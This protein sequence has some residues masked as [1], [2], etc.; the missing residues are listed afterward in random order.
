M[1]YQ[2]KDFIQYQ[3]KLLFAVVSDH[4]EHGKVLCF[5]RY[6]HS[7]GRWQKLNTDAANAYLQAEYPGFLHYSAELDAHVH[8]VHTAQ[9]AQHYQPVSGLKHLLQQPQTDPVIQDLNQLC[10]LLARN[11]VDMAYFG[12]TGSVLVG[13]Q[14]Q[15]SD[16]DLVCYDRDAFHRTRQVI[17]DLIVKDQLQALNQNDWLKSYQRRACD[18]ALDDY[19]W[20]EQRKFNK[21]IFNQRKFDLSL[22]SPEPGI[23]ASR[24]RKAGFLQIQANVTDDTLS[25]DTPAQFGINH[26]LI[27]T[28]VSFT[29]T[30][31]G[32]AGTGELIAVAGQVEIDEQGAQRI[33]VGSSREAI[34]EYI[35]VLH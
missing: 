12:I 30:Y 28:V 27:K 11:Q 21:A 4:L 15:A 2:S 32:Q 13:V 16:L 19:I 8:A 23:P 31:T 25:Y 24:Y 17:Q 22:L 35:R 26:P 14:N 5:L 29:A 1:S 10:M 6:L 20:H 34:G 18:F 3:S 7:D 33:V 9:I